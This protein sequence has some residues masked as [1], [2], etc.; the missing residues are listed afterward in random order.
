MNF[1][2][3]SFN[4]WYGITY[5]ENFMDDNENLFFNIHRLTPRSQYLDILVERITPKVNI[6]VIF[7]FLELMYEYYFPENKGLIC[8]PM[9]L[10]KLL[11]PNID[12]FCFDCGIYDQ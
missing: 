8:F 9:I 5:S 12:K 10:I 7:S 6:D 1:P 3:I 2:Q 11:I 4:D